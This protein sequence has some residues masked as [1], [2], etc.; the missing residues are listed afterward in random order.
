MSAP[1]GTR[2]ALTAAVVLGLLWAGAATSRET[3]SADPR[4]R[5]LT[6]IVN[7]HRAEIGCPRLIWDER[8]ARVA[9]AHSEDMA[10]H[11]YFSHVD[12]SGRDPFDRLTRAGISFRAAAENIAAG[13]T[14]ARQVYADWMRSRGHRENLENCEYTR[15]GIGVYRNHWT[16]LFA[17]S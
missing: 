11:G 14:S 15:H 9:R 3:H 13:Q 1:R 7:Q 6:T 2:S 8:L 5:A 12:R 16:H 17:R 10:R 4:I